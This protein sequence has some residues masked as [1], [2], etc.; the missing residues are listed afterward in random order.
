MITI[1]RGPFIQALRQVRDAWR[2]ANH[3]ETRAATIRGALPLFYLIEAIV[4]AD[5]L[6]TSLPTE[7]EL[8]EQSTIGDHLAVT[9]NLVR[10]PA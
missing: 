4:P 5:D 2:I 9:R 6:W 1:D 3:A 8:T 7:Q 10:L